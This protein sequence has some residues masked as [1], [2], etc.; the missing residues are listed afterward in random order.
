MQAD[1]WHEDQGTG[2]D[3]GH[4][5]CGEL[6][7][8][9]KLRL[10]ELQPGETFRLVARDPGAHEDIPAWCRLTSN[11]LVAADHPSYLIRRQADEKQE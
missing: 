8:Q 3:A 6:V 9:L 11:E 10:R 5:G 2:W 4:M 1:Q 7:I